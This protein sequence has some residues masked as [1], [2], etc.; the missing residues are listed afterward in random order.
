MTALTARWHRSVAEISPQQWIEMIGK[1]SLPFYQW[2]WLNA[3]ESS[4]STVPDQGWQPL[5][6]A[7]WRDETPVAVAPLFVKGHSY[8]E[9]VFDQDLRSIGSRSWFALLPEAFGH[10]PGEPGYGLPISYAS[11]GR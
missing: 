11:W 6:L 8:G 1:D 5:H 10:E 7:L 2:E 3:L 9:F 4:G